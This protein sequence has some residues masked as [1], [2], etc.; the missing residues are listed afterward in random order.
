MPSVKARKAADTIF[1]SLVWP[2]WES[3]PNYQL[4]G[5]TL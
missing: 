2:I 5:R 1:K 4:R 3:S